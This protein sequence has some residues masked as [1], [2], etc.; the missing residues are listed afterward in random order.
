MAWRTDIGCAVIASGNV[1]VRQRN[2]EQ[3]RVTD[4]TGFSDFVDPIDLAPDVAK[5]PPRKIIVLTDPQDRI[6]SE[7]CQSA[8]VAALVAAGVAVDHRRLPATDPT[9]HVLRDAALLA[10]ASAHGH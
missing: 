5:H 6:V 7:A 10:A 1:A 9:H 4:V 8:Y 3:Q 2:S